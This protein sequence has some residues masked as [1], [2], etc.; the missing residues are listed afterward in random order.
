[1]GSKAVQRVLYIV[2]SVLLM[3]SARDAA[4][5]KTDLSQEWRASNDVAKSV[6]LS[7]YHIHPLRGWCRGRLQ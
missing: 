6:I 5:A 4:C 3:A 1:M 2:F 7:V